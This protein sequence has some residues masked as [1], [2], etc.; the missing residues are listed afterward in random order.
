MI[1]NASRLT[2]GD[3]NNNTT[4]GDDGAKTAVR[5]GRSS[6]CPLPWMRSKAEFYLCIFSVC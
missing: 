2:N 1:E 6:A 3:V 5:V 4:N